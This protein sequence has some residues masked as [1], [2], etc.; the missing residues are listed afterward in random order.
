MRKQSL[1]L[2]AITNILTGYEKLYT[3]DKSQ[4]MK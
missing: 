2:R 4:I 3:L 1:L